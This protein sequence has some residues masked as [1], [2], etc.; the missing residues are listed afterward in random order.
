MKP[1]AKITD[2]STAY[3]LRPQKNPNQVDYQWPISAFSH[4]KPNDSAPDAL[5]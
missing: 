5:L 1:H 3:L 2:A 4:S